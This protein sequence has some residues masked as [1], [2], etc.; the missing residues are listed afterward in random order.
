MKRGGLKRFR[1]NGG[2]EPFIGLTVLILM[3]IEV[4][5]VV[6]EGPFCGV[7]EESGVQWLR[8]SQIEGW[9]DWVVKDFER[10]AVF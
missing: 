5:V 7:V 9:S 10:Q 4:L 1:V 8:K 2:G 3:K 6:V